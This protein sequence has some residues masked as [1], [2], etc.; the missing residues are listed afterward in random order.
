MERYLVTLLISLSYDGTYSQSLFHT[1]ESND[2]SK[3]L[4]QGVVI[5][6]DGT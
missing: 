5:L 1:S 3:I 2:N 6:Y 4:C